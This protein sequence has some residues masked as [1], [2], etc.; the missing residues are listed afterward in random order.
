MARSRPTVAAA[1]EGLVRL[2][3]T[4]WAEVSVDGTP[5]GTTPLKPFPLGS[6]NHVLR[7]SHPDY[8]PLQK[9]VTVRPGET[10]LIEIDLTQEAFR[11]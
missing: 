4:P 2:A 6:G 5:F 1:P 3:V 7:F 8:S 11:R 10:L 9:K